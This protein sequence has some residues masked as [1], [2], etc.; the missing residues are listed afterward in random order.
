MTATIHGDSPEAAHPSNVVTR[1]HQNR[2]LAQLL[3]GAKP[4]RGL[5]R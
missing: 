3:P 4:E 2:L 5:P 1:T